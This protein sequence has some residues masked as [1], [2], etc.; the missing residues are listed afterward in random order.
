MIEY[1]IGVD[2]G[3]TGA[4]ALV[5]YG[6]LDNDSNTVGIIDWSTPLKVYEGLEVWRTH[7][8]IKYA[9]LERVWG[10]PCESPT[11]ISK[12]LRNAGQWE[13]MLISLSIPYISYTPYQWRKAI[14]YALYPELEIKTAWTK[15]N[16]LMYAKILFPQYHHLFKL[17]E[18][19]DRAEAALMGV[20]AAN[21]S[22]EKF[23]SMQKEQRGLR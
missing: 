20:A 23:R 6:K 12:F 10:R 9:V 4:A 1:Y 18:H 16:A 13:G 22:D 11:S 21:I 8:Y 17:K 2:P 5:G 15:N 3:L 19:H 7:Y 14:S